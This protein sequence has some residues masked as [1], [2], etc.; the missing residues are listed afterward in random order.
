MAKTQ[1]PRRGRSTPSLANLHVAPTRKPTGERLRFDDR[2][3]AQ[4]LA[5]LQAQLKRLEHEIHV[6]RSALF[7][8]VERD[9]DAPPAHEPTPILP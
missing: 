5:L 2:T 9:D 3:T 7:L 6:A 8:L 4:H 1:P